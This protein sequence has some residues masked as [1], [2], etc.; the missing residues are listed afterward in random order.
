M[1]RVILVAAL[2]VPDGAGALRAEPRPPS[3]RSSQNEAATVNPTDSFATAL[4]GLL[5]DVVPSPLYEDHSHW[6]VQREVTRGLKWS[7]EDGR[8][9]PETLRSARNDGVWWR[10]RVSVPNPKETLIL[11]LRNVRQ[12]GPGVVTFTAFVTFNT[13]VEYERERWKSGHRLFSGSTRA[14]ARV[15]LT[16]DCEAATRVEAGKSLIPDVVFRL[17]V[18]RSDFRYNGLVFEHVAG[19]GGE[20]AKILGEAA[21]A[22]VNQWR[23]SLERRL[24]DK[25]KAAVVKAGDTREIRL[26]LGRMFGAN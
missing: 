1:R 8:L 19:V 26:S 10:V 24:I 20:G 3:T 13:D 17:R 6:D 22:A 15:N 2:L 11:E 12:P 23:P 5:V 14:R 25:A 7:R 9:R 18:V 16:L 21:H 4:R